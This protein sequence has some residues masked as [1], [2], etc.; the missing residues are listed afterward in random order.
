[1][2]Y[3]WKTVSVALTASILFSALTG[4]CSYQQKDKPR[5]VEQIKIGVTLYK[6][7]DTFISYIRSY[8][9]TAA[10]VREAQDHVKITLNIMDGKGNQSI[11]NDQ[12]DKFISQGYDAICVNEVDR[13]AASV[14]IDKAHSANIPVVFFN[15]EPVEEDMQRW[16]KL[17]YVGSV[18]QEAGTMQGEIVASAFTADLARYDRDGDGR[19]QYVMIEGEPG[20]QDA[21]IRTEYSI[22][23]ITSAGID[24]EK[25]ANDTANWQRAQAAAKMALWLEDDT[26]GP[27][28][29]AVLCNNDDMA[30]GAID[31]YTSMERTDL[32]LIVGIDATVPAMDAVRNGAMTGTVRNDAKGQA[33]AI[34]D[35]AY[36]LATQKD[37]KIAVPQLDGQYVWMPHRKVTSENIQQEI[38]N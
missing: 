13:T 18:A 35:L 2:N 25:L 22:K 5:G 9:E 19:L 7:D 27:R 24:V 3:R 26:I 38:Q 33:Q 17:Y 14:I 20:H 16:D 12:V 4:G 23:T 28:I 11:Q 31:A 37:P 34:F 8:L 15:R 6:L 10:K 21:A 29:E 32:P 30:L 1:M 36:A